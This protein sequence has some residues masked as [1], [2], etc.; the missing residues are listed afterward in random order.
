MF[1]FY[2]RK[3]NTFH[4]KKKVFGVNFGLFDPIDGTKEF[5]KEMVNSRKS[6]IAYII[7]NK[8]VLGVIFAPVMGLLYF[9]SK[10]L[11][12]LQQAD[13]KDSLDEFNIDILN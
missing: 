13:N 10:G 6:N 3:A 11:S 9:S 1:Q 5:I 12:S 2:Q 7:D 4:T 8:P